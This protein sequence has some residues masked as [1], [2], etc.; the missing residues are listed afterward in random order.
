[1]KLFIVIIFFV[2]VLM[3][4]NGIYEERYKEMK[5]KVKVEYRFIPRSYYD[6]QIFSNQ[7]QSKF[8]NLFDE[9]RDAWIGNSK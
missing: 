7:F 8:S 5:N 2:G 4:I 9:E 6:E 3:I 1:M